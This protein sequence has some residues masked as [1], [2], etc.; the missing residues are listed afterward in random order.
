MATIGV[1]WQNFRSFVDTGK[2]D[3]EPITVLIGSNSSGKTSL[4]APLLLLKQ[5]LGARDASIGLVTRGRLFNAGGYRDLIHR[6]NAARSLGF[7][8]QFDHPDPSE[9]RG[10]R[11]EEPPGAAEMMFEQE[12]A[13]GEIRLNTYA[14]RDKFRRLMF[15][16]SLAA[17]GRFDIRGMGV[18]KG[19]VASAIRRERPV[20]FMFTGVNVFSELIEE[21]RGEGEGF[22]IPTPAMRYLTS[23]GYSADR[24]ERL[25][26]QISYIGPLRER[27]RRWYGL[28]EEMPESVGTRGQFAPEILFRSQENEVTEAIVRWL[29]R[30]EAASS[31]SFSP[32]EEGTFSMNL[33]PK[34]TAFEVSVADTGFGVSQVLPLIV[35]GFTAAPASLVIAEQPEI[36]LNPRFQA[37]LANLFSEIAGRGVTMLVETHSEHLLLRLR[38]LIAAGD[39]AARDV[40]LYYVEKTGGRSHARRVP[41]DER[42]HIDPEQ[43]PAGFF[44]EGL[45]DAVALARLQREGV[46]SENAQ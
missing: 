15:R 26:N 46:S 19:R 21:P 17:S 27:P 9:S 3:L 29:G 31:L 7:W 23:A 42:G 43:W 44:S 8:L 35:Q 38:T 28:S 25:L 20:H 14:V 22:E 36:H 12:K 13:T 6:H 45:D 1:R 41:I 24:L 18:G 37:L 2:I 11:H 39:V 34:G 32:L 33:K 30:F 40:A 5:T 16:R 4:H 10:Q